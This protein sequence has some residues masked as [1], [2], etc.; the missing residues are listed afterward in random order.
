MWNFEL[1]MLPITLL[2]VFCK[3]LIIAQIVGAFKKDV[4]PDEVRMI[5]NTNSVNFL[6]LNE[7]MVFIF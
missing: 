7:Q 5:P 3:N 1:Y 4:L 6:V 2:L